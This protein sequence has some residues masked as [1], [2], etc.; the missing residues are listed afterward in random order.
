MKIDL[1]SYLP[2]PGE[3]K[4]R[5]LLP[6]QQQFYNAVMDLKGP[7]YVLYVGGVGSG[8]TVV[9]SL[10]LLSLAVMYPGD[11]LIGRL[12]NPELKVTSYKQ[13]MEMLPK[14][15]LLEHKVADQIVKIR[16]ANGK[17]SNILFRGLDEPD[18]LRS[19]NLNA[20][21]I[22][23]SS[24]VSEEAFYL[25]Q[26][27]LRGPH[28]RKIFMTT[29]PAGHDYQYRLFVKQDNMQPEHKRN[30]FVVRAPSTENIFLP[31]GYVDAMKATYSKER[32]EREVL[33]SFD[34]FEG[35]IYHEF[36]RSV[37]VIKPFKIPEQWTK[38]VGADHGYRNPAAWIWGAINYDGDI[39]IYR[40]FYKSGWLIE[41]ICKGRLGE[42]GVV[43]LN[44][45]DKISEIRID[46]STKAMRGQTG[47][48]DYDTYFQN[49]PKDWPLL[50]A[51]NDVAP[52]ID[53]VKSYLKVDEKTHKPKIYIFD[54]CENLIEELTQYRYMENSPGSDKNIKEEP[55][56]ANDH[57]VDALRYLIMTL[58]EIPVRVDPKEAVRNVGGLEGSL[59]RDIHRRRNPDIKDPFQDY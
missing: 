42:P 34:S 8:K 1:L 47:L 20:A 54:T 50:L 44:S 4:Q 6:K 58:P 3:D 29:N 11:Y 15:L 18:K 23:E 26:S 35:Q 59:R 24:Q 25:L 12:F 37:H 16:T 46:P 5:C 32:F 51:N 57:A 53:R 45:Q 38:L 13:F 14:E 30:F 2:D 7:K 41:E 19:L 39:Y 22:D 31:D 55:R 36:D 52:G 40:E 17:V 43:K 33:G 28:V 27:R 48:S 10:S 49:I 56:K 9:G 21:W